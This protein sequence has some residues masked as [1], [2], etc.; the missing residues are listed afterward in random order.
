MEI[1]LPPYEEIYDFNENDLH[2]YFNLISNS[3]DSSKE[4]SEKWQRK[5]RKIIEL[6]QIELDERISVNQ[7]SHFCA[8]ELNSELYQEILSEE[9]TTTSSD[10]RTEENL[11]T[12]EILRTEENLK[13]EE[14]TS[15]RL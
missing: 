9:L 3:L 14:D 1:E 2:H 12:E 6:I 4:L 5:A 15:E 11:K 8:K 7:I 13:N 10:L